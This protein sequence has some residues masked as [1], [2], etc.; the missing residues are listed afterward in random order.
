MAVVA[1]VLETTCRTHLL[2]SSAIINTELSLHKLLCL[3]VNAAMV[4]S[5]LADGGS[6]DFFYAW[7]AVR[8]NWRW[9]RESSRVGAAQRW[10]RIQVASKRK[11][12]QHRDDLKLRLENKSSICAVSHDSKTNQNTIGLPGSLR[13]E[14]LESPPDCVQ[15]QT[16][17]NSVHCKSLVMI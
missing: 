7:E 16:P 6:H 4:A 8:Q 2:W 9:W 13:D 11:Q 15:D 5:T 3:R 14:T 1:A 10:F 12:E 17:K